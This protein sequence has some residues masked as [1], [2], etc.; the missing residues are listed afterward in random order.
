MN[1]EHAHASTLGVA[2]ADRAKARRRLGRTIAPLF[3]AAVA[4]CAVVVWHRDETHIAKALERLKPYRATLQEHLDGT[5]SLPPRF[6]NGSD[7]DAES[8]T[9]GFRYLEPEIIA[10]ANSAGRPVIVGLGSANGL[11]VRANGRA[12]MIC[13]G[14]HVRVEWRAG[15]QLGPLLEQQS[16]LAG[17][18]QSSP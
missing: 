5:G 17:T 14:D 8:V 2:S 1:R 3:I 4:L 7:H 15:H 18:T 11:I 16:R 12:V 6:P 13:D 9:P 10:W